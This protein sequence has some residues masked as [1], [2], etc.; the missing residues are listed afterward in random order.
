L[1]ASSQIEHHLFPTMP[2]HQLRNAA[3]YVEPFCKKHGIAY[4]YVGWC[5]GTAKVVARLKEIA[6]L[7]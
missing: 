5:E 4:E 1:C 7:A 2:R 3:P 6:A